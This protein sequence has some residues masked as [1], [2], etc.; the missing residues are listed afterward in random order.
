MRRRELLGELR[1]ELLRETMASAACESDGVSV[2]RELLRELLRERRRAHCREGLCAR[3]G[4][5]NTV[6]V[7]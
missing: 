2:W 5:S 4:T 1:R 6:S 3:E 7:A